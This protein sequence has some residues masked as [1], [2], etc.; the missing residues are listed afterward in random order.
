MPE[1]SIWCSYHS[2][3]YVLLY[4]VEWS[5]T[6][7]ECL[8]VEKNSIL[9][10]CAAK[11]RLLKLQDADYEGDAEQPIIIIFLKISSRGALKEGKDI[12]L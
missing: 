7:F 10:V 8:L 6:A 12:G 2:L 9:L 3:Q 5:Q 1:F 11:V 4:D